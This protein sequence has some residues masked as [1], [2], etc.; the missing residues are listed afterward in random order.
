MAFGRRQIEVA[1]TNH[2]R[3]V[4]AE[5]LAASY[6]KKAGFEILRK[7]YKTKFGEIDLI[8]QKADLICFVEVKARKNIAEALESVTLRAQNRIEKSALFFISEN[9]DYVGFNMRFDVVA[10]TGD[11]VITHLDNAWVATIY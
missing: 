4:R 5:A 3:G 1:E 8:L 6:L 9:P 11:G 10:I 2:A 7:R